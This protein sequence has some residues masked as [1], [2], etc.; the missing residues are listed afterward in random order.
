MRDNWQAAQQWLADSSAPVGEGSKAVQSV[1][2]AGRQA[3]K[4]L[5]GKER[6]ELENICN[7]AEDKLRKLEALRNAGKGDSPEAQRLAIELRDDLE[8]ISNRVNQCATKQSGD[9]PTQSQLDKAKQLFS[10]PLKDDGSGI[11]AVRKII[12]DARQ[13]A[14]LCSGP[15]KEA[16]LD[17]AKSAE[18]TL[19]ELE[20]AIRQKNEAKAKQA[21]A[22]LE[23]K[24]NALTSS[25]E[26]AS[27]AA[28][29]SEFSG[30]FF[31]QCFRHEPNWV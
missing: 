1:I 5:S 6:Q 16:L 24:V 14:G 23:P 4:L 15:I 2:D 8:A 25:M 12:S 17:E 11:K 26:N 7:S 13:L 9:L 19:D 21:A 22:E 20:V 31:E 27:I 30:L 10:N 28:L 29:A 3:A 18:E